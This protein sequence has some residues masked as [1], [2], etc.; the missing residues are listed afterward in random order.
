[1][2]KEA[3][4][5]QSSVHEE[6]SYDKVFPS[7]HEPEEGF[8]WSLERET[9]AQP[10]D[11]EIENYGEDKVVSEGE[12]MDDKEEREESDRDE[13][14]VSEE[15]RRVRD[16]DENDSNEEVLESTSGSPGDDCT[17]I[18]P[19]EWIVNDFLL[20]MSDKGFNSLC[21]HYQILDDIPI[22]LPRNFEKCYTRKTADVGMYDAMFAAGLRLPLTALHR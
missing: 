4:S 20:T 18:L 3:T 6:A 1:M 2:S 22:R 21:N 5:E 14:V 17:F 15:E 10:S 16:G 9:S 7:G 12:G 8:S 19:K 13:N 11:E